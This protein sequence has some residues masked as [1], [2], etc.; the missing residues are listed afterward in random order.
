[1]ELTRI[2]YEPY[3]TKGARRIYLVDG[4]RV[5]KALT[6][7]EIDALAARMGGVPA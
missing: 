6:G 7:A 4:K 5:T 2:E 3:A 1:M